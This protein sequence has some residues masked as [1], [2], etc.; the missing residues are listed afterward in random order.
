MQETADIELLRQYAHRNSEE[1]FA[2]LVARHVNMVYSTALR[3]TCNAHAAEEITQAV[4]I[5]LAKKADRLRAGT[6]LSGWL[7]Q[8]AR[9]ASTSFLRTEIRRSRREQEAYMRSLPNESAPNVWPEIEPRLEDAMG[10][11]GEKE[12]DALALRFFEGK[13]FQEIG[14]ATGASE[15][16][17]KKRVSHGLEKLRKFFSKHGVVSTT[18]I[19]AGT[20]SANS[21][22][23]APIGLTKTISAIALAKGSVAATST[24]TLVKA[25]MKT[26]TWLK[27][28][29]TLGVSAAALLVSGV[30]T[31]AISQTSASNTITLND[32]T[33]LTL[34]GV[35]TGTQQMAPGYENLRM[36]NRL[37]TP[38]KPSML[39]I[40]SENE[41]NQSSTYEIIV[42]DKAKTAC[43][44]IEKSTGSHVSVGVEIQG[45]VLNAFPRWDKEFIVRVRPY[46]GEICQGQ[47]IVPNPA[48][49]ID[50]TN[51][52]ADSLPATKSDGDLKV[53]LTKLV[54]GAATPSWAG[55]SLMPTNDPASQCVH[56]NFDFRQNGQS[57]TNLDPWPVQTTDASGN[58]SRGLIYDYP[59]NGVRRIWGRMINGANIPPPEHYGMDGYYFQPGLWPDKPWKVRLEFIQRSGFSDDEMVTFT[60]VPVKSGTKQDMDDEWSAWDVGK[61]NFPFTITSATVKG[62]HLK[63]LPPL[64]FTNE[65]STGNPKDVSI[66][67]GADPDFNPQG[68]NLTV[69]SA[70]DDQGRDLWHPF[71]VPWAGHYSI[72]IAR[73]HDDV[74]SVNLTL[75]LHK[76]R[77]VEFT[78]NPSKE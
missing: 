17:A 31:V 64:M 26:M 28:K 33:K 51:W 14:T 1:A 20:I 22:Q 32:G 37:Y 78:V 13:S 35:T 2:A 68:M 46:R 45:F 30:A 50:V 34:L 48:P 40:K 10:R 54:A 39:W 11:L 19:I 58:W 29:F 41:S 57:T 7:Y 70:T 21:V 12:R 47:F 16:A 4:F 8:S 44:N 52:I 69:V 73:V 23:A 63:L 67:I 36:A 72:E 27:I 66:I 65:N 59:T 15:N 3:K 62:V 75:A 53:T 18:A 5:I 9:L 42:Y 77:F 38:N 56:L 61:T 24:I 25:T 55:G 76:S 49:V 74:K 6:I 43:V 71:G 60:N